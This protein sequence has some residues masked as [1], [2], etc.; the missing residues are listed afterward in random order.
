MGGDRRLLPAAARSARRGR[1]ADA[2][3]D[4]GAVRPAG[5]ARPGRALRALRRATCAAHTH[6]RGRR[7]AARRRRTSRWRVE[8]E[9]SWRRLRARAASAAAARRRPAR[10][11][12]AA[13]RSGPPRRRTRCC[14]CWPATPACACRCAAASTPT[15]RASASDW[16]GGFWLPE[17]AYA[18]WLEPL[19]EDAGVRSDV[20]RADRR[21]SAWA[22]ASTCARC[23]ATTGVVLVP[24]DRA[25]MSLVWSDD[26]YPAAGAYRDY[27][28]HT[29]H[30]HNP[31]SNDGE[32]LRPRARRSRSAASTPP[33][34]S[35]AR[36]RACASRRRPGRAAGWSCAR[37]T[38]S[39][40][41]TGGTRAS[42]GC[43]AVVEECER[44]GLEL[45]RLDD[46]LRARVEP[47]RRDRRRGSRRWRGRRAAGASD[48]D[49]STWSG[50]PV[51]EHGLRRARGRAATC[52]R[53]G[54]ARRAPA[55]CASCSRC[56]RATGRS[57]S[58]RL[59]APYAR[60]RFDGPS[61]AR[62]RERALA[63]TAPTSPSCG[64]RLRDLAPLDA[65][66]T[67][68][69]APLGDQRRSTPARL[70]PAHR[71]AAPRACGS[72]APARR[73]ATAFAGNV[74]W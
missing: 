68:R 1:A 70:L 48:G 19:L 23:A 11:A 50:P 74:A 41:G 54:A 42:T 46:A 55:R 36:A 47:A 56:R 60:E 52:S 6:E 64:R 43:A 24:I 21:A 15:A 29:I 51:A 67:A 18:P 65:S 35:R 30:H 33:T 38:P 61:R 58:P 53:A 59:A 12:R 72:R 14:R 66:P 9:R 69:R 27:H 49:L 34:S 13:R 45:L 63:G 22:R 10:R 62:L 5:G 31:W 73:R 17:C 26:G 20:R 37:S 3:A 2:V 57:C 16:R 7:R 4:P 40:S 39:C 28:H 8:L 32:R 71:R 25:T 44:Q